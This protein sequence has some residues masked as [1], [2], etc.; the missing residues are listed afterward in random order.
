MQ[1]GRLKKEM[2]KRDLTDLE[3]LHVDFDCSSED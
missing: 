3:V 2:S 1:F